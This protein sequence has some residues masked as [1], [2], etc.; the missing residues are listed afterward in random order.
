[1]TRLT[2]KLRKVIRRRLFKDEEK[3]KRVTTAL[4]ILP[5]ALMFGY[6]SF[7]FLETIWPAVGLVAVGILISIIVYARVFSDRALGV[8]LLYA[9]IEEHWKAFNERIGKTCDG[10]AEK[11]GG[12]RFKAITS[13]YETIAKRF[14][15]IDK[16]P[17]ELEPLVE[18]VYAGVVALAGEWLR[19]DKVYQFYERARD[20]DSKPLVE[21]AWRLIKNLVERT[22]DFAGLVERLADAMNRLEAFELE[23][24]VAQ[25]FG[26]VGSGTAVDFS[27]IT[28]LVDD[29]RDWSKCLTATQEEFD[30]EE[31]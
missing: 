17:G 2:A 13:G 9:E 12:P 4:S 16:K 10:E 31:L 23:S 6:M 28:V 3:R 7:I 24:E 21:K 25:E 22:N 26:T 1:M 8:D 5:G 18:D 11:F 27:P 29:M 15:D 14:G 20:I 19:Q 30:R